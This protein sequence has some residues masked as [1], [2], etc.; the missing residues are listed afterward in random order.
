MSLTKLI[1][2]FAAPIPKIESFDRFL[3]IGPH[4]DDIEIG[5]G[6][7]AAKLAAAGKKVCFLICTDGRY[8]E[9]NVPQTGDALAQLRR[10]E[11][12]AAAASLGIT[13]VRF[14]NLS[15][16]GFYSP[17]ELASGI[18]Q[19][20]G[21]F[22]PDVVLAP[23]PCVATEGHTDHLNVGNAVRK[24]A[25]FANY[26]GIM[27]KYGAKAA[28]LKAVAFFMTAKP[29][30]YV[31]TTGF[32]QKQLSALFD[33]HLSQ[34]PAGDDTG[35]MIAQYLKLRARDFGL[36]SLKGQAEGFRVLGMLHMHCMPESE[37]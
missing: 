7:T 2:R 30:Q 36:R 15:D 18:A 29:N 6:A 12:I 8:G 31:K 4:P 20:I 24:L 25:C 13:D 28:K 10:E 21:D 35:K 9:G 14:L 1:L 22:Q 23:D 17:E 33:C 32:V 37:S 34:F 3:F 16:G 27:Q 19:I 5:A 11:A 26:P